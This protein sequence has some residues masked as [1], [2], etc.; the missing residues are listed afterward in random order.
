VKR[1]LTRYKHWFQDENVDTGGIVDE[2]DTLVIAMFR[3]PF[4]WVE[5]MRKRV[6]SS[7]KLTFCV[8][9]SSV[10]VFLTH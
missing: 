4:E 8:D 6:S 2:K 9:H 3:N 7:P 5:A 10:A 1:R